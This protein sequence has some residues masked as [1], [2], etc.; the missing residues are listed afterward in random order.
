MKKRAPMGQTTDVAAQRY[1]YRVV[2][3]TGRQL[4]G[5]PNRETAERI[6]EVISQGQPE[7]ALVM[8][9]PERRAS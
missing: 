5:C 7:K 1:P 6:A 3:P 4:A 8:R 2:T 9:K